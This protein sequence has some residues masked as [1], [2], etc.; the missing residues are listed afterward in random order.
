MSGRDADVR[1]QHEPYVG[2]DSYQVHDKAFFFG[3]DEEAAHLVAHVSASPYTL[4]HARSGTGKTSLLNARLIPELE[5]RGW[6]AVRATPGDDPLASLASGCLAALLVPPPCEAAALR[7]AV[8]ALELDG[9][10]RTIDQLVAAFKVRE[11]DDPRWA[12]PLIAPVESPDGRAVVMPAFCR[13]LRSSIHVERLGAHLALSGGCLVPGLDRL[14]GDV[15]VRWLLDALESPAMAAAYAQVHARANERTGSIRG[16]LAHLFT[17]WRQVH[18]AGPDLGLVLI[19]DQFE[20]LFTRFVADDTGMRA[21]R[22]GEHSF[23]L[24][25]R[26]CKELDALYTQPLTMPDPDPPGAPPRLLPLRWIVSMRSEY[27]AQLDEMP[28]LGRE[29]QQSQYRL[30]LLEREQAEDAIT[31][32]AEPFGYGYTPRCVEGILQTLAIEG[33]YYEPS[34]I[35]IVCRRLWADFGIKRAGRP[36]AARLITEHDV[37]PAGVTGILRGTVRKLLDELDEDEPAAALD[38]LAALL[39]TEWTRNVVERKQLLHAPFR[40][41]ATRADLLAKMIQR[42][43]V[44]EELAR[45]GLFVEIT[46]EFLV[47]P[48]RAELATHAGYAALREALRSLERFLNRDFREGAHAV[49]P[50][51]ELEYLH[52]QARVI[53]WP[54]WAAELML[55]S[56]VRHAPAG[57]MVRCWARRVDEGSPTA[58]ADPGVELAVGRTLALWQL[59]TLDPRTHTSLDHDGREALLRSW[60]RKAGPEERTALAHF[61]RELTHA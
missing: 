4:L 56:A 37:P 3:R 11:T 47:E 27:I 10:S 9:R 17:L 7:R 8:E 58:D 48:I 59:R 20:E 6:T 12:R 28:R 29:L 45:G 25:R 21:A 2:H 26:L 52:Q 15:S 35:Q 18:P 22:E 33:E 51:A 54:D 23:R 41:P 14:S 13:L 61:V 30:R 39:T 57:E 1:H 42:N 34:H 50:P 55:R 53:H 60:L 16:L 31:S 46:H 36:G 40:D 5:Q 24:R 43:L 38:I 44:R 32:P 49:L 19:L